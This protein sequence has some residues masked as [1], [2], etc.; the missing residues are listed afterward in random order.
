MSIV[1][2]YVCLYNNLYIDLYINIY[3]FLYIYII[4]YEID[5][6]ILYMMQIFMANMGDVHPTPSIHTM[7]LCGAHGSQELVKELNQILCGTISMDKSG[8]GEIVVV[9][10]WWICL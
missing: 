3:I 6:S 10:S 1:K 8:D 2:T 7:H 5:G 4:T 9:Y